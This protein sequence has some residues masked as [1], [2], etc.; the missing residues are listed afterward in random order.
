MRKV[1]SAL[2]ITVA[3]GASAHSLWACGQ[4]FGQVMTPAQAQAYTKA[5]GDAVVTGQPIPTPTTFFN[6]GG[7]HVGTFVWAPNGL[8]SNFTASGTSSVVFDHETKHSPTA[9]VLDPQ[10]DLVPDIA[11]DIGPD[12]SCTPQVM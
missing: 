11:G 9:N 7:N 1:L 3:L 2:L 5:V 8:L 6:T 4:I 10:I 12:G